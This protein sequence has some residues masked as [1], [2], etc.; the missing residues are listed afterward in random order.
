MEENDEN[1]FPLSQTEN[2]HLWA[3]ACR[4]STLRSMQSNI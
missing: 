3:S 4:Y 1:L 2:R